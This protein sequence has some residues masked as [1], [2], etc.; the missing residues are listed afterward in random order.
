MNPNDPQYQLHL[1][2]AGLKMRIHY[3]IANWLY[4]LMQPALDFHYGWIGYSIG[5]L[6][7]QIT[8][9]GITADQAADDIHSL[10]NR[11]DNLEREVEDLG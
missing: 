7:E 5:D 10:E 1:Y 11:V 2:F 8:D 4:R 9:A 3:A 6:E